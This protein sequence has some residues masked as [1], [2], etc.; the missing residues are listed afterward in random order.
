MLFCPMRKLL[1]EELGRATKDEF[2]KAKKVEVAVVLENI[3]SH[4]NVGSI[5]RTCDAFAVKKVLLCG[6]TGTPPHRDIQK[7]ALGATE[8]VEWHYFQNSADAV[9]SL[10]NEGFKIAAVEQ[11][12]EAV[13]LNQ[14]QKILD[15]PIAF[16]FGNEVEGVSEHF[17]NQA[18]YCVEIPQ[19]GTKHSLNV[20]VSAG[21]VL[22]ECAKVKLLSL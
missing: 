11:A 6:I 3:R 4:L 22:W 12:T 14:L 16:V 13:Q 1:N 8:S 10:Q 21:A 19:F 7:T 2:Q 20:A 5:F 9:V 18:D 15:E 17:I